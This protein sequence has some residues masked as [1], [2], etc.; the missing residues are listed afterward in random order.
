MDL[1]MYCGGAVQTNGYLL[2]RGFHA[3]IID[4]PEGMTKWVEACRQQCDF[5]V[6]AILLTHGH[7]DHIAD[8][9]MLQKV[10]KAPVWIHRD[11]APLL[12]D[13][14]IQS[15][16]NPFL[17]IPSCVPD[18]VLEKESKEVLD[19]FEFQT[20]L[21]PGHCP[22]SLCFYFPEQGILL[23]GDVLFAGGVGRWDLPGGSRKALMDAIHAKI[24]TLPDNTRVYPGH[25]P[26]TTVE[27]EKRMNPYL[28]E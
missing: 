2:K 16:Y 19:A 14:S 5:Q 8:A 26:S 4:A 17:K 28:N 22:G 7:W 9:A 15:A 24:L 12:E 6:S 23:G 27:M 3:L 25:G 20:L 18:R 21:C 1:E 10:F 13:P 11:S